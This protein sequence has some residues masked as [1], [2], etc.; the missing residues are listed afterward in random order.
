MLIQKAHEKRRLS[1]YALELEGQVARLTQE[2]KDRFNYQNLVGK[3][4]A[5]LDV[6]EKIQA[7]GGNRSTVMVIGESG[8]GKE[9][10]AR[11]IHYGGILA[12]KPFVAVN[13]AAL[14]QELIESELFGY[15][16]G[17][18]T[19]AAND[20]VGLF[21]A[22]EGGTLFLDEVTE[23]AADT[24]AK[25]L[26]VLQERTVRPVGTTKE[27][28]V[29]VRV[30]ASSN[31]DLNQ[32]VIQGKLREDL[33]YRLSVATIRVPPLRER[34]EDIPILIRHI[35][36]RFN[37]TLGREVQGVDRSALEAM[38][39]YRWP[40]NVRELENVLEAA[41][42]FGKTARITRQDLPPQV[43]KD[44]MRPA[45]MAELPFSGVISLKEAERILIVRALQE[46]KG[47]KAQAARALGI[48]RKQFY[49]KIT[50]YGIE[51]SEWT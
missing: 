21:K 7:A 17:A 45:G 25:L 22:A 51:P 18:F 5:M 2:L 4:R 23:M 24:Q 42:T 20:S 16:K 8:T 48:S 31:R 30:I 28:S 26:R 15:R 19:G 11:A 46:F 1:C 12:E 39:A 13:C 37:K 27:I 35:I 14:P 50:T 36:D 33:Y 34:V 40:G 43:L 10:V 41:F 6:F 32:A 47:N 29:D 9:L 3:S 44:R 38:M 49:V